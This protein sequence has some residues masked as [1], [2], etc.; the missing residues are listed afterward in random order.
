MKL[1]STIC[2][3]SLSLFAFACGPNV[4]GDDDSGDDGPDAGDW[5]CD[6]GGFEGDVATCGDGSDNDC[7]GEFDCSDPDCSGVG[8]CPVCGEVI[9]DPGQQ[10]TLP[11]GVSSGTTCTTDA[12]CGGGT[13]NCVQTDATTGWECHASYESS[14]NVVGFGA[15]QTFNDPSIISSVCVTMEHSWLRDL[16]IRLVAPGGQYVRLHNF[17]DRT[18][19]E[20]YLGQANDCD[21][22]ASPVAGTGA[23]YCWSPDATQPSIL[24]TANAGTQPTV[25]NCYSSTSQQM[26]PGTYSAADPWTAFNGSPMNGMWTFM[27]TDLWGA[28]NGFVFDWVI[29]FNAEEVSDC[30]GPIVE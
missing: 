29:T 27:V 17:H 15:N 13:P 1:V 2:V 26:P 22:A 5:N 7:D 11:D 14:L 18:G 10:I 4:R 6:N 28:D 12:Q 23:M 3:A 8:E 21:T 9:T 30:S 25:T 16:D 20:V 24:A 19:G